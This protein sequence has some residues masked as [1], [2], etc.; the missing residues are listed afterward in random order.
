MSHWPAFPQANDHES[1]AWKKGNGEA[2]STP[3]KIEE[4]RRRG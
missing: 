4:N 2:K 1:G 3:K